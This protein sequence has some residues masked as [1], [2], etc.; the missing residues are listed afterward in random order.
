MET[1][2]RAMY[3]CNRALKYNIKGEVDIGDDGNDARRF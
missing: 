1:S 2:E 3:Q